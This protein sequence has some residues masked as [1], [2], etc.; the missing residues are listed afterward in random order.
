M[1]RRE[2]PVARR[3]FQYAAY[4]LAQPIGRRI[5][6]HGHDA[7][8]VPAG[9]PAPIKPPPGRPTRI[10][11]ARVGLSRAVPARERPAQAIRHPSAA[12]RTCWPVG[13]AGSNGTF[14][15]TKPASHDST[16]APWRPAS[17]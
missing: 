5:V 17:T 9:A 3:L 15:V 10:A 16:I 8:A 14:A 4:R 2:L 12:A 11:P 1:I 7:L 13:S 6:G